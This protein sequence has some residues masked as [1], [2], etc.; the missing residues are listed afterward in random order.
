MRP[1]HVVCGKGGSR[2][3]THAV[4]QLPSS[5][6][7]SNAHASPSSSLLPWPPL[8]GCSASC[9]GSARTAARAAGSAA[10]TP[11]CFQSARR[12]AT[13]SGRSAAAPD[14][15]R[16]L[17]QQQQAGARRG[18]QSARQAGARVVSAPHARRGRVRKPW[19]G[20]RARAR[21]QWLACVRHAVCS[22]QHVPV[23]YGSRQQP[24]R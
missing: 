12:C 11:P 1:G 23:S 3:R 20:G 9:G 17:Q 24:V 4:S 7:N 19:G 13:C 10:C 15:S 14:S 8:V 2:Y 16:S 22:F 6:R 18:P 21:S 5:R